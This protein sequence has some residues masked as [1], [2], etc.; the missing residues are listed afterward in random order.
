MEHVNIGWISAILIGGLAG[1]AAQYYMKSKTGMLLNIILGIVGA[2]LSNFFFGLLG[3][4][5][6]GWISY[7]VFGFVG[8]CALIW[9]GRKIRSKKH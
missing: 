9:I 8:A 2:T 3:I 1:W 4:R 5:I 6:S 7:L